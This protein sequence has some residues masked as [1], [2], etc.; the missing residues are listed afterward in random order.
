MMAMYFFFSDKVVLLFDFWNVHSPAGMALSVVVILLLA[1]LYEVI[2]VT[3]GKLLR[4]TVSSVP[5]SI[6]QESLAERDRASV[7]SERDQQNSTQ[8]RWFLYHVSQT[9]LHVIQVVIGYLVMLAVMSYNTWIFLG[10][11][12]GSTVGYYV[13]YPMLNMR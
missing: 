5:T 6:S 7:N 3:K 8:K 13:A 4:R 11:I 12:V 1:A 2:K 10:V 9:L